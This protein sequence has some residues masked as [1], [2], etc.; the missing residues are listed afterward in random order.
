MSES[1]PS[2]SRFKPGADPRVLRRLMWSNLLK[3]VCRVAIYSAVGSLAILLAVVFVLSLDRLN[4]NL[5]QSGYSGLP[6]NAGIQ[7]GLWGTFWLISLTIVISIPV[8]IGA[9]VYLEEYA[10]DNRLTR[11]IKLNLSNL[12][13]VPSIVY[14]MLGLAVF[15]RMFGAFGVVGKGVQ[16]NLLG[17]VTIPL[18][19]GNTVLAGALTMSLLI[20]PIV[21]I[22][23]QESLRAI[24][25]SVRIA[26]LALGATRWQTI[27][28]Q[29]LPAALPGIAT[30]AILSISRA[31]GE[32]APLLMV[33][34]VSL[35]RICPGGI[36]SVGT[37]VSE[38]SRIM[39]A[40]FD[41]YTTMPTAIYGFIKEPNVEYANVAA[42]A[43]VVLLAVL[44]CFNGVAVYIRQRA[45]RKMKF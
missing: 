1:S 7:A 21:I 28:R 20:L 14:G 44:T 42:A 40:P 22:A 4:L 38:P 3:L 18:P 25:K 12:A 19:F 13:G 45:R 35:G 11:F 10:S 5:F 29:I 32:T 9:A 36:K 34:A 41:R 39:A 31:I 16:V 2:A 6:E 23:S 15:V 33:G 43:I 26:S 37:L 27:W 8:G 17:L 30:G 24:P